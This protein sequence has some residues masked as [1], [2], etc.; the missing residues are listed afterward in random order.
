MAD[1]RPGY[2]IKDGTSCTQP[3]SAR[4]SARWGSATYNADEIEVVE[5]GAPCPDTCRT[6]E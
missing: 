4:D 5:I 1:G 2:L 6:S 3:S